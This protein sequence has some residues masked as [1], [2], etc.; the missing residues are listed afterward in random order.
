MISGRLAMFSLFPYGLMQVYAA[1]S[2]GF[3]YARSADFL[4]QPTMQLLVWMR[5]PGDILFSIGVLLLFVLLPFMLIQFV[6][7][8]WLEA[9]NAA[10]TPRELPP[11]TT[12]H[13][14]LTSHGPVEAALIDR[15]VEF[16]LPYVVIVD[17]TARALALHDQGVRVMVGPLDSVETYRRARAERA[18]LVATTVAT[19][20]DTI[21][22]R[23]SKSV[24]RRCSSGT[25]TLRGWWMPGPVTVITRSSSGRRKRSAS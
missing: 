9:R 15:L 11:D 21:A 3:W 7:A 14:I 2:E 19:S 17:D 4:Q 24:Q 23:S 22:A 10:R 8:P 20:A 5:M 12:G 16:K 1:V 13:V 18:S 25:R 6:Y